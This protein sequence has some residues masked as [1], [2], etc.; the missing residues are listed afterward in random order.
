MTATV[1]PRGLE[2]REFAEAVRH[3]LAMEESP[4]D[5]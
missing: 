4:D 3:G 1:V 5:V 2:P